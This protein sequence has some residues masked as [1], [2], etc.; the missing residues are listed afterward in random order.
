LAPAAIAAKLNDGWTLFSHI[1][2]HDG[3][4]RMY[5]KRRKAK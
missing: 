2:L 3:R 1:A 5:F 4:E